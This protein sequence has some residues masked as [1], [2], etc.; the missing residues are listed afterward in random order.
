MVRAR[1]LVISSI[2]VARASHASANHHARRDLRDP[3]LATNA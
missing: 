3:F 1:F 2:A